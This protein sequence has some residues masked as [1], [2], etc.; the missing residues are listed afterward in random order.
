[1]KKFFMKPTTRIYIIVSLII[2]GA[3]SFSSFKDNDFKIVK[4]LDIYYT[5]F[6]EL[7]MFYVDETDPEELV[8]NSIDGML[9]SL[10]P[11]TTFVPE[12]DIDELHFMTTGEYGGIGSLIR[13]KGEDVIIAEP[14]ENFPA[15]DEG[16]KPG[17]IIIKIDGN[18]VKNKSISQVSEM[19]KGTPHTKVHLLIKRPF[20]EKNYKVTLTRK[21]ITINN[22]P[23]YGMLDDK[24]GYIRLSNF[25]S[26]A[27]KE[28]REAY[29]QLRSNHN[30][31]S[32]VLD[33]RG[34]PGGLLIEA[35][36]AVNLFIPANKLVVS[37]KGRVKQ[38]DNEYHTRGNAMDTTVQLAILVNRGSASA[39]EIVA[40]AIQDYD[41]GII[42][43]QRTFGK[44]LVQ[45]TRPLSYNN[46][47]KVTTAKYYIPSGR[48]IQALDYS[49][50]NEDGSVGK[51][52]DSL[53]N[54]FM[55]AGGRKV[56]D[57]GGIR[58]DIEV[59]PEKMSNLAIHLYM[60]NHIFDYANYF[61]AKNASIPPLSS[62]KITDEIYNDFVNYISDK[63]FDYHTQS[64]E[65]LEA[66]IET[67]KKEKYYSLAREEFDNLKQK[68]SHD[69]E[70]DLKIFRSEVQQLL[71]EEI[72]S[73][74]YFQKGRIEASLSM[75]LQL[76]SALSVLKD[77][78]KVNNILSP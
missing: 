23:Y 48:C 26:N 8:H 71:Y 52:P 63:S 6:R 16:L 7:N 38:W 62:F 74:Y 47:L 78:E 18:T 61:A 60:E 37:T 12:S 44:G 5:L 34:N 73:R 13:K 1:M 31:K 14:Y 27:G 51:I 11:Y 24:I 66:L 70:K 2:I 50:R 22:V 46:Q 49:N 35:V 33:L 72:A 39:S 19:L 41:R 77:G 40:G 4:N 64:E 21:K 57:G 67:A 56:Y 42:V 75:D 53:V 9:E 69:I 25:T 68:I 20:E 59:N 65:E 3:F 45:T 58:P 32:L 28:L 29:Q 30:L 17:D 10:D 54:E 43:G 55:T 15:A 36:N 76:D